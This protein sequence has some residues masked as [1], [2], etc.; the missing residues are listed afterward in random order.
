MESTPAEIR[1]GDTRGYWRSL[2]QYLSLLAGVALLPASGSIHAEHLELHLNAEGQE[3]RVLKS[4]EQEF[5]YFN[6]GALENTSGEATRTYDAIRCDDAWGAMKYRV[7]LPTGPGFTLRSDGTTLQLRIVEHR[8]LSKERNI[9]AM[10]IHCQELAPIALINALTEI[11]W[12]R[13]QA[14]AD[15]VI[16]ANGYQL[17]FKYHP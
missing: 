5:E 13:G 7:E 2:P 6:S 4:L 15:R 10:K 12:Q 3:Y 11:E 9:Q 17:E 16:L 8:V 14:Q 1:H